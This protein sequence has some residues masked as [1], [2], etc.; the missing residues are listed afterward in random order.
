MGVPTLTIAGD[1]LV[2]RQGVS[3]MR[4]AGLPEWVAG[5]EDG[6]VAKAVAFAAEPRR[7]GGLRSELRQRLP[8]TPLFDARRFAANLETA[9]WQMWQ[10]WRQGN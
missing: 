7:L 2:S 8:G 9:L 6:F 3:L 10:K 4:A 1:R 5:D